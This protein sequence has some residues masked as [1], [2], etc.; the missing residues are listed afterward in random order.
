MFRQRLHGAGHRARPTLPAPVRSQSRG[1]RGAG[2]GGAI[3]GEGYHR[4]P[5]T[6]HAEAAAIA[7]ALKASASSPRLPRGTTLYCT[8]EPCCHSGAGKRTPPCTEAII[9]AGV[10]RV[11]FSSR[12]PNP[13]VSG[14]GAARLRERASRSKKA[15]RPAAPTGSSTTSRSRSAA[16]APS[17]DSSGPRASTAGSP[18]E[19]EPRNGSPTRPRATRPTI[20]APRTTRSW[21]GPLPCARTTLG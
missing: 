13:L 10:E 19:A 5:G 18:A 17:S 16:G 12:D 4:G 6:P 9:A 15:S 21:S 20:C 1:R 3:L 2:V 7:Y 14:R 11:V 8:L